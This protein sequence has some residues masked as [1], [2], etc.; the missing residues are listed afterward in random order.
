MCNN[1]WYHPLTPLQ[2]LAGTIPRDDQIGYLQ[3]QKLSEQED[4]LQKPPT[5]HFTFHVLEGKRVNLEDRET[6][7]ESRSALTKLASGPSS[8]KVSDKK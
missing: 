4:K 2:K 8:V 3:L 6:C 5:I 7:L 1:K